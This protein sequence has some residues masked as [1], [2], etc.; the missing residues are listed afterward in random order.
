[1]G[2]VPLT[3][4][5]F[6]QRN[7]NQLEPIIG[8]TTLI[9]AGAQKTRLRQTTT[10]CCVA[11]TV[12]MSGCHKELIDQP[13]L[14]QYQ[15]SKD[16]IY[17]KGDA[18]PLRYYKDHA[19]GIEYPTECHI[20]D[21]G[22][23]DS[24]QPRTL[25]TRHN[26]EVW[27]L[28]LQQTLELALTNNEIVRDDLQFLS[29][30][31]SVLNN[32]GRT[33]SVY[34]PALQETGVLFGNRGVAAALSDFDT[35]L[36]TRMTW[37]RSEQIQ[38]SGFLNLAAGDT[39]TDETGAWSSRL[40]KT[41]GSGGTFSLQN[42][43]NYSNN[44]VPALTKVFPSVFDGFLQAEYRQPLGAGA[45][46]E[47]TRIAG[48][49][50][51]T[52][53]GVSGV[54]QGV[55]ISKINNDIAIAQFESSIQSL[56]KGVEDLYWSLY[57]GYQIYQAEINA[58]ED[59]VRNLEKVKLRIE[60]G[61]MQPV[62]E[63][64]ALA[65]Y[66][67]ADIRVRGSLADIYQR[68]QRLRRLLGLQVNDGKIIRPSDEPTVAE[69]VPD[70]H[71]SLAEALNRR[72]ELRSQKWNLKS[73][74]KQLWA[75][76]SL[77][78]PRVDGILNYRVNAFG[79]RLLGDG[80]RG[81]AS[82]FESLTDNDQ[83]SWTVGFD[84]SVP[85]GLRA[86]KAQ[87][88]NYE[89]QLFKARKVM[90]AAE[91]EI[92]HELAAAFGDLERWK[93]LADV[94]I[95]RQGNQEEQITKIQLEFESSTQTR[96]ANAVDLLQRAKLE[97]RNIRIAYYESL[98]RYNNAIT[99]IHFRKGTLLTHN[100]IHLEEGLWSP[101]AYDDA[102]RRAWE[103]SYAD[104]APKLRMKPMGFVAQYGHGSPDPIPE[105]APAN[106]I[107]T[108]NAYPPAN[109][110]T[111]TQPNLGP[112]AEDGPKIPNTDSFDMP[113][114]DV[115]K[116]TDVPDPVA[117]PYLP[118]PGNMT[119][120]DTGLQRISHSQSHSNNTTGR[121]SLS[122]P[123]TTTQPATPATRNATTGNAQRPALKTTT[124]PRTS[125]IRTQRRQVSSP[126]AT[127][128]STTM[129]T[130]PQAVPVAKRVMEQPAG[131]RI[132]SSPSSSTTTAT[133]PRKRKATEQVRVSWDDHD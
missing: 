97:L 86:A 46:A 17:Y 62:A 20:P 72:V 131:Q 105:V 101:D 28:S 114:P 51:N 95:Q 90:V 37:G 29:G 122:A 113:A 26:D 60:A 78:K 15:S 75:A 89:I 79:D 71:M 2:S 64:Q 77:T 124:I 22:V 81:T 99:E 34:D 53:T 21:S 32:P 128:R 102:I 41:F 66:Y 115:P 43:W 80:A 126:A 98:I 87:V 52:L 13:L 56:V 110:P 74:E 19:T 47:F 54:S 94:N 68:E 55:V 96:D 125:I 1:M 73:I 76:R 4:P 109:D 70:W 39:L 92:S 91:Q 9:F 25:L 129:V 12:L 33:P 83:T 49:I 23:Q 130:Q 3:V 48:P 6:A 85:I 44:N 69:F 10:W 45:G 40:E 100:N 36:T 121:V 30:G 112:P 14:D 61:D 123:K 63:Q 133:T 119:R 31:N 35:R 107:P 50:S 7:D 116:P 108:L 106:R 24:R 57:L 88:R 8:G 117:R 58:M 16:N 120:R 111:T 84:V 5:G 118:G 82:A 18:R 11:L 104:D 67:D 103:R 42:D 65:N 132:T 93:G 38:N 127:L 59:A 27:S